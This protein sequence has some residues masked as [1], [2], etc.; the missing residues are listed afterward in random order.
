MVRLDKIIYMIT[1]FKSL[2][3]DLEQSQYSLPKEDIVIDED[4]L[5]VMSRIGVIPKSSN[6][7]QITKELLNSIPFGRELFL[8]S[9]T[10]K[11]SKEL[12][13]ITNPHCNR[14]NMNKQC[15]YNNKKNIWIDRESNI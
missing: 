9:N 11:H 5:R 1:C 13:L 4:I 3:S 8:L 7:I 6:S 2:A 12:C 10:E 14:C 15:D